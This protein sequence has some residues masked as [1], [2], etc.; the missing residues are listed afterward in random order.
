MLNAGPRAALCSLTA[1]AAD[2][3]TGFRSD[4]IHVVV[5]RRCGARPSAGTVVHLSR[6]FDP[7]R[8]IHPAR[9]PPRT[10]L[11]RSVVDAAVWSANDLAATSL[12]AAAVQQRLVSVAQL[13]TTLAAAGLVRRRRLLLAVLDDVE[14]GSHSFAEIDAVR[15][16]HAAGIPPPAR[17][18]VRTDGHGRRR[19][20]DLFWPEHGLC[21]EIDGAFHWQAH[22]WRLDLE[23]QNDLVLDGLRVLRFPA[24][25]LRSDPSQV[26]AHIA[27]ALTQPLR[28]P[29]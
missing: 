14:G 17:Q 15:L 26:L 9:L 7:D 25:L 4:A 3:L 5:P 23:R 16:C 13:R 20:L 28:P 29:P 6:R 18:A 1:A 21:V 12:F 10:R 27:R 11:P 2:G 19:Y 24:L 8:D 22:E